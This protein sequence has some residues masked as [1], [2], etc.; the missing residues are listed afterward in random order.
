MKISIVH[1]APAHQP[2]AA[3]VAR[4]IHRHLPCGLADLTCTSKPES[5]DQTE[6]VLAVFSLRPGAFAPVVPCYRELRGKKVA[7]M[8]ILTGAVDQS[9]LRKTV[10]G[11]KKQFC[12]NH[13]V[14]GYLCPAEDEEAWGLTEDELTKAL[15]F[16]RRVFEEYASSSGEAMVENVQHEKSFN[17]LHPIDHD[18]ALAVNC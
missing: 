17:D 18:E 7:F 3:T 4:E 5:L 6:L 10:W 13:V 1:T 15:E 16:T 14:A 2:V 12:G 8:A 11:V 9:R